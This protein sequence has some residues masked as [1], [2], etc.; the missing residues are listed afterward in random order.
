LF[1]FRKADKSTYNTKTINVISDPNNWDGMSFK[2]CGNAAFDLEYLAF[3]DDEYEDK[4]QCI[5]GTAQFRT[6]AQSL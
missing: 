5:F 4:Y 6:S 3:G 2:I 1:A